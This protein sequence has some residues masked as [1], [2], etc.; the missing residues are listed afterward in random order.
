MQISKHNIKIKS[1]TN[2]A[3]KVPF[4]NSGKLVLAKNY[5]R[6]I[7][8]NQYWPNP[9]FLDLR[10]LVL[11]KTYPL[12][13]YNNHKNIK[14]NFSRFL[15]LRICEE[16]EVSWTGSKCPNLFLKQVISILKY[17]C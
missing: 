9:S 8:E 6:S 14:A 13:E 4:I 7:R 1:F 15:I 16:I 3:H 10:K 17:R 2:Q 12:K 5:K 11:A